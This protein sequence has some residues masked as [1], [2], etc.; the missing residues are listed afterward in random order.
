MCWMQLYT[1]ASIAQAAAL[2]S[3]CRQ[4][5]ALLGIESL[6]MALIVAGAP[7]SHRRAFIFTL[8]ASLQDLCTTH[9]QPVNP[10]LSVRCDHSIPAIAPIA[11]LAISEVSP[12]QV[13][14]LTHLSS[15]VIVR[16]G[17]VHWPAVKKW[18]NL[19]YI[20][21]QAGPGRCVPVEVGA[22]Y[23]NAAW[24]QR[25]MPFETILSSISGTTP[26][27]AE[28]LYLAQY[29]LFSQIPQLRDDIIIPDQVY[30]VLPEASSYEPPQ[31][32]NG[33]DVNAWLGP[34]GTTSPAHTDPYYNA[35]G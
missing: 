16:R 22:S 23:T 35:Y 26:A 12:H 30:T 20:Q 15:P 24:T 34:Q 5:D 3:T 6:D 31:T 4:S 7:G 11:G 13:S 21:Q 17:A 33:L 2:L 19:S 25:I 18:A 8:M 1:D 9:C 28:V 14:Y 29:D 10:V 32:A 27:S